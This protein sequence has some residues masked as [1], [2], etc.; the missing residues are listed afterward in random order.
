MISA[1]ITAFRVPLLLPIL[2]V[3]SIT[4][5]KYWVLSGSL[6]RRL[7]VLWRAIA[8][9]V[10]TVVM[11][12]ALTLLEGDLRWIKLVDLNTLLPP[13]VVTLLLT[14]AAARWFNR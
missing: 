9:E 13:A 14:P 4:A 7:F 6:S 11:H 12:L 1:V 8:V 10:I 5:L 3:A 2:A